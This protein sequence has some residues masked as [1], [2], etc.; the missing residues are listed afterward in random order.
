[1]R[2]SDHHLSAAETTDI[3]N[4][5]RR[6]TAKRKIRRKWIKC[7]PSFYRFCCYRILWWKSYLKTNHQTSERSKSGL[8]KR[9]T[10]RTIYESRSAECGLIYNIILEDKA[11]CLPFVGWLGWD[12]DRKLYLHS[13]EDKVKTLVE[14]HALHVEAKDSDKWWIWSNEW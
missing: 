2:I 4:I 5:D 3:H 1:M 13:I 10:P 9:E 6:N 11:L 8:R 7:W 12:P 14:K